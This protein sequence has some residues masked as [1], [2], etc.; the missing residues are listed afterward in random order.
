ML[1]TAA[2]PTE[3]LEAM[4]AEVAGWIAIGCAA[5]G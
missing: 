3:G 2:A 1:A 4:E 5:G